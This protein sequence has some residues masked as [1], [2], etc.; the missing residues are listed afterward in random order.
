MTPSPAQSDAALLKIIEK[1][2][3]NHHRDQLI[4]RMQYYVADRVAGCLLRLSR[5]ASTYAFKIQRRIIDLV[6]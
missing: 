1:A 6:P 2:V 3:R 5:R 4:Y